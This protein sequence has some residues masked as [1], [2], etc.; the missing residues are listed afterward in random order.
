MELASNIPNFMGYLITGL[1]SLLAILGLFVDRNTSHFKYIAP[2]FIVLVLALGF[3]QAADA[4]DADND[5]QLAR[6]QRT[7]LLV[8]V[9]NTSVASLKTSSYL[10]DILLS[11]PK[12]LGDFGLTEARAGKPLEELST[13][14]LVRGEILAANKYRGE[15]I[16]A[17]PP[18]DRLD[19]TLWYYNKE[20]DSPALRNAL[21]EIGFTV[22]NMIAQQ[23]QAEDATNAVWYGPEVDLNDYKAVIVSLIRAGIDIRRTGPS[24]RNLEIKRG[25]IEI[26]SSDLAEGL[27]DGI[28]KPTKSIEQIR[29]ARDFADLRDFSCE[30]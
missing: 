17:R 26:G 1:G 19:T 28:Q 11:Q 2:L 10:T 18:S 21:K 6:E 25:V 20:I 7:Q 5:S 3:F 16:E 12:I 4:I 22:N 9:D 30:D 14:E 23:N 24:C 29:N 8:L 15:L 27:I 13:S